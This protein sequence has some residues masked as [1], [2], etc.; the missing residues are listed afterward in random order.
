MDTQAYRVAVLLTLNDELS[1]QLAR[2]SQDA[3]AL[4]SKFTTINKTIQSIT[5]SANSATTALEKMNKALNGNLAAQTQMA[6]EY[7]QSMQ[8]AAESAAST[9]RALSGIAGSGA[10]G[11][12][13]L[14]ASNSISTGRTAIPSSSGGYLPPSLPP[15]STSMLPGPAGLPAIV[16]TGRSFFNG[17]HGGGTI[18]PMGGDADFPDAGGGRNP[19]GRYKDHGMENLAIAYGGFET[20][21]AISSKG[22]EFEREAARLRQM[23][24]D[25]SQVNSSLD[26]VKKTKLPY[27][28]QLDMMRIYT[29]AQGSFRQSGMSGDAALKAAMTMSPLLATYEVA[30]GALGG[31]SKAAASYNMRN[32]NKTVEIMG[33]L[34]NTQRASEIVDAV[35]KASQASGRLVDENQLK[36]F[37]AYGS[38]ATNQQNIRTIF[39]G[40]EP[41]IAEMGG[42]TTAV[43]LRTAYTRMNGMMSLPPKL[44]QY[45]MR[46]LGIADETGRKQ[47]ENLYELE[48][49]DAIG[50]ARKMMEVYKLHGIIK[51]PDI[52]RENA[53]LFGTNGAKIYNRLMAQMN[54]IMESYDAYGKSRGSA[55][56]VNDPLNKQLMAQQKLAAKWSDL[57]LVLAKDGGALDLFTSGLSKLADTLDAVSEFGAKNPEI[58][59]ATVNLIALTT[60]F[61]AL[62]GGVWLLGKGASALFSPIELLTGAKGIS[63]LTTRLGTL[64]GA[65]G[66]VSI[67]TATAAT[68]VMAIAGNEM[69]GRWKALKDG[70]PYDQIAGQGAEMSELQRLQRAN[71]AKSHP[72]QPFPGSFQ[73]PGPAYPPVPSA[74]QVIQVQSSVI[75]DGKKV[76]D[77]LTKHIVRNATR[78]P[79]STS[80]ADPT[81]SLIYPGIPSSTF[82]N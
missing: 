33:G 44:L 12:I 34:A 16:S 32:L 69:M 76:G 42:S 1:K 25:N 65:I 9:G 10:G 41:I 35:F 22:V 55:D 71:W 15:A 23:G 70:R 57:E 13:A 24:L 73:A 18:P 2:V 49:T 21:K 78:A 47:K 56:V 81:M 26:F 8:K 3:T 29:D 80:A 75:L 66:S 7:A 48:A 6:S 36:Q 50:Y 74:P 60:T 82:T 40:L 54:T 52:E 62:R 53:I 43:G 45:E 77:A 17:G 4:D 79:S 68:Y 38:S 67:A 51:Q 31:E 72:G 39:A 64:S 27:T 46:R 37:V 28:S 63:L 61:A 58:S 30:M 14:A 11:L 5:K 20:L 59:K 19:R